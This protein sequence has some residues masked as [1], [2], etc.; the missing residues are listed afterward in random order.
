MKYIVNRILRWIESKINIILNN[1]KSNSTIYI[2]N[3]ENNYGSYST[4]N[5]NN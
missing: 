3:D 2:I 4:I 5:I 1:N